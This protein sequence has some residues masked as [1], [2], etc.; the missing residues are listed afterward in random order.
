[1]SIISSIQSY[2][3]SYLETNVLQSLQK[4]SLFFNSI[5]SN[6]YVGTNAQYTY[7]LTGFIENNS[8]GLINYYGCL[9][10]AANFNITKN[11]SCTNPSFTGK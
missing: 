4:K 11:S 5:P 6:V 9:I 3:G 8:T 1:M 10:A 7:K 2:T